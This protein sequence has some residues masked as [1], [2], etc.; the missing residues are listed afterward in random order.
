[1]PSLLSQV[2]K[3]HARENLFHPSQ[4]ILL[5]LSGG[6]DS[7]VLLVVLSELR[8][9]LPFPIEL[10][11]AYVAVPQVALSEESIAILKE[12]CQRW[13]VD[14]T[15][16]NASMAET[17]AFDCYRCARLRRRALFEFAIQNGYD[18][19]ALGHNQDDYLETGLLNLIFHGRLESLTPRQT[20]LGGRLTILRPLL[21]IPKKHVSAF[22][23]KGQLN[24]FPAV[25]PYSLNNRRQVIRL[26]LR[27]LSRINRQARANLLTAIAHWQKTNP[28]VANKFSADLG[29]N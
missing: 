2:A 14:F 16:L 3:L 26:L 21:D 19:L 28:P 15:R 12:T 27:E 6:V 8:H 10:Q 4:R 13:G 22:A 1:M 7:M 9:V 11:A 24:Y 29:E 18:T 20:M 17:D 23:K 25:C 5:G